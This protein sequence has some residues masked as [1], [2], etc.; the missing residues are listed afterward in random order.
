MFFGQI[1]L[2]LLGSWLWG[3]APRHEKPFSNYSI[4]FQL[5]VTVVVM[6]F[7]ETLVGQWLPI[8]V[9]SG[10]L[11]QSW[12]LAGLASAIAFTCLHGYTD[13]AVLSIFLG[14]TVLAAVFVIEAR[15]DGRPVLSTY[16]THALA[17]AFVL[18]LRLL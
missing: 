14:A 7:V 17:N 11:R 2:I 4:E 12:W 6:P 5:F 16:L 10:I 3:T 1:A 15:R 18:A 9:V 8:R 13:R